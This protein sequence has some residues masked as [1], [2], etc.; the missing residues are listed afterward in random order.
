MEP[1]RRAARALLVGAGG[2]GSAIAIALLEAGVGELTICDAEESRV[3]TLLNLLKDLGQGRV[4]A[5][6]PDPIRLRSGAQCSPRSRQNQTT[7]HPSQ[8]MALTHQRRR[9]LH[10][11]GVLIP[12]T[13]ATDTTSRIGSTAGL[14]ILTTSPCSA[15]IT[16][17]ISCRK[18]GPAASTPTTYPNGHRPW[19]IDQAPTTPNQR[20][21]PTTPRPTPARTASTTTTRRRMTEKQSGSNTALNGGTI[22][23]ATASR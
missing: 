7:R 8:T 10:F 11:P 16:T 13:T 17:P 20:P 4:S 12:P 14:L 6:P 9:M 18:A 1:S 15:D 2:A 22:L 5:G 23:P 21:H 19:W 3:A